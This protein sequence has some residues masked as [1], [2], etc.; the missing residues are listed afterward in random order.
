VHRSVCGVIGSGGADGAGQ[1]EHALDRFEGHSGEEGSRA[2]PEV[3]H[4]DTA[5]STAADRRLGDHA[6]NVVRRLPQAAGGR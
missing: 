1:G 3:V 6:V 4:R 2:R 5:G